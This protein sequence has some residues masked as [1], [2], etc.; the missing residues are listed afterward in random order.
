MDGHSRSKADSL[1]RTSPSGDYSIHL[2]LLQRIQE[3][4]GV[5]IDTDLVAAMTVRTLIL[6]QAEEALERG[7][8]IARARAALP[9]GGMV[10]IVIRRIE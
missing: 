6:A 5:M 7:S 1:S 10:L 8:A 2:H 4:W 3:D 9:P